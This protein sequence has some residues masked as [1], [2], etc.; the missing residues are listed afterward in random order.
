VKLGPKA[1]ALGCKINSASI[2]ARS[3]RV[4]T[5]GCNFCA[6]PVPYTGGRVVSYLILTRM[7]SSEPSGVAT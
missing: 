2:D 4:D 6:N 5:A 7:D 1:I 3:G